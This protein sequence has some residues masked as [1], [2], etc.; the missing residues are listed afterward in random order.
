MNG[1]SYIICCD[2]IVRYIIN[3]VA[4][5]G[6][7]GILLSSYIVINLFTAIITSNAAAVL[8]FPRG[9]LITLRGVQSLF[10]A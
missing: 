6:S 1:I 8:A 9:L 3:G 10:P 4:P 2:I 7:M 5:L